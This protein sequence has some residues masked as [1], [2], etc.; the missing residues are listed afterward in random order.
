M[1]AALFI[2]A[3]I[4]RQRVRDRSALIFAVVT[5]LLLAVAFSAL[6]APASTSYHTTFA[7]AD[8]DGGTQAKVLLDDVFGHLVTAGV[9]DLVPYPTEA[10]AR[11]AV[12]ANKA[13]VAIVIPAGFTAAVQGG[14]AASIRLLAGESQTALGVAR[15]TVERYASLVNAAQLAVETASATG[16]GTALDPAAQGAIVSAAVSANPIA[17]V[18]ESTDR[19]QASLPTFYAAAMA[20]MFVFFATQYGALSLIGERRLGTLARLLAAPIPPAAIILGG[21]IAA[22]VLGLLSM[23]VMV[24]ATSFLIHATWGPPPIVALL[25]IASV[26]AAAGISTLV[27]RFGRTEEQAGS[28]NVIVALVLAVLGGTFIPLSQAPEI[29]SRLSLATPHAWF[30]RAIDELS[31]PNPAFTDV[32]P[33][34][35]VLFAMG[36]VTGAIGLR[37]A[38]RTLVAR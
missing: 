29:L 36:I 28:S 17:M 3:R 4:V 37:L 34:I 32:L 1:R 16:T 6:V 35:L 10:A 19:R 38:S 26:T 30:L 20:I 27:C 18:D 7:V 23:T 5:P 8:S 31:A 24:V 11:E 21:A 13:S 25:M 33:S 12:N 14:S 22:F 15:S 9:A 2:A